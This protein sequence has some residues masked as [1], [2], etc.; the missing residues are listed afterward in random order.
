MGAAGKGAVRRQHGC[1]GIQSQQI[2]IGF[3]GIKHVAGAVGDQGA[4]RQIVDEGLGDVVAGMALAE[5][6]DAHGAGEQAKDADHGKAR[7]NGQHD[8]LGHLTRDHGEPNGG[9][10]QCQRQKHHQ[11]H[12]PVAPGAVGYRIAIA[13][14]GVDVGHDR[15]VS[16]FD[17]S[18]RRT[19]SPLKGA[20]G[21]R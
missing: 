11:A 12:A 9:S 3:V 18:P 8:R 19:L 15:Q 5:M 13:H 10:P 2:A 21:A 4:L 16:R 7:E 14:G 20:C 1:G 17:W 6:E